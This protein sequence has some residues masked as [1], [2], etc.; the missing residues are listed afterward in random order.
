MCSF[1]IELLSLPTLPS[2]QTNPEPSHYHLA[3]NLLQSIENSPNNRI[4]F[5]LKSYLNTIKHLQ[6]QYMTQ[7]QLEFIFN[8]IVRLRQVR[9]SKRFNRNLV[10]F[11]YSLVS[12]FTINDRKFD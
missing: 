10:F 7:E 8:L 9:H 5:I 1:C 2:D 4:T 6:F 3:K 12:K 11:S